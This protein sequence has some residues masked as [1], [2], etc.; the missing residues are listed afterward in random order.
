MEIL[1]NA[2]VIW[3]IAGVILLLLEFVIPGIFI[4]FFGIGAWITA[5]CVYLFEP[6]LG[7]QFLIFSATS[8]LSLVFLRK[9]IMKKTQNV[10]VDADEEFIGHQGT[11][12]TPINEEEAGRIE[13]KG[14]Q[15]TAVSDVAIEANQKVRIISKDG[16][17][18]RVEPV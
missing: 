9:V 11:C 12:L 5:L 7:I 10:E 15:W 6:S 16:L 14:T 3:F 13:F 18:L 4:M 1:S 17:T 2:A 8:I